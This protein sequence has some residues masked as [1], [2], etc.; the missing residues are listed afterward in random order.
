MVQRACN[1]A[2]C[3]L[4]GAFV[5]APTAANAVDDGVPFKLNLSGTVAFSNPTTVPPTVEFHGGGRAQYLGRFNDSGVAILGQPTGGC[6][7]EV[8][9][10]PN[11]HIE[12]SPLLTEVRS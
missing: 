8:P 7:G 12:R 6:P 2:G 4:C 3:N 11:V 10:I 1:P 5:V 9:G